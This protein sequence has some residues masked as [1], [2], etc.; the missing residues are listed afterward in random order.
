MRSPTATA[1]SGHESAWPRGHRQHPRILPTRAAGLPQD[2][3]L[4]R[5]THADPPASRVG[6]PIQ[7]DTGGGTVDQ[8]HQHNAHDCFLERVPRI[9]P[10]PCR[11]AR[12]NLPTALAT[13]LALTAIAPPAVLSECM[14]IFACSKLDLVKMSAREVVQVQVIVAHPSPDAEHLRGQARYFARTL[15]FADADGCPLPVQTLATVSKRLKPAVS[16]LKPRAMA[17]TRVTSTSSVSPKDGAMLGQV[18]S[19]T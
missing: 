13:H 11:A 3:P 7:T 9:S 17:T 8:K 16:D 6:S 4:L 15:A 1:L 14:G 10:L 2:C 19:M 5:A 12:C 18:G